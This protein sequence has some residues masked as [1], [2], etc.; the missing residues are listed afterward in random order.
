MYLT[1]YDCQ[2]MKVFLTPS[3]QVCNEKCTNAPSIVHQSVATIA[4]HFR[5]Q[6]VVAW[7]AILLQ[8]IF[9]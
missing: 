8:W 6:S 2:Y 5:C 1:Y 4:L 9:P 3:S 7:E